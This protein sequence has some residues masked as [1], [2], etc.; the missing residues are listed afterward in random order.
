MLF[1]QTVS[2]VSERHHILRI[3]TNQASS[4]F[5]IDLF[6]HSRTKKDIICLFRALLFKWPV[7]NAWLNVCLFARTNYHSLTPTFG[8]LFFSLEDK[9]K[10]ITPP[11]AIICRKKFWRLFCL[12]YPLRSVVGPFAK[13]TNILVRFDA[14]RKLV[15]VSRAT[16]SFVLPIDD[17]LIV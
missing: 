17:C 3:N 5:T 2:S 6:T 14:F 12:I 7:L 16:V 4:H 1:H 10:C 11:S 15:Y 13:G 8:R 9:K